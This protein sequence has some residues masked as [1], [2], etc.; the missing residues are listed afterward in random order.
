MKSEMR[1]VYLFVDDR[2]CISGNTIGVL[3]PHK[4]HEQVFVE[5]D[6]EYTN[7]F[8]TINKDD[9]KKLRVIDAKEIFTL[10]QHVSKKF[11]TYL[12]I[13]LVNEIE[14]QYD[15][16]VFYDTKDVACSFI[17]SFIEY[18]IRPSVYDN[19]ITFLQTMEQYYSKYWYSEKGVH[20]YNI[21]LIRYIKNIV[22]NMENINIFNCFDYG[23]QIS[24]RY[25]NIRSNTIQFN[26]KNTESI[27]YHLDEHMTGPAVI[28]NN[29]NETI[30]YKFVFN[31][32]VY[33]KDAI[34]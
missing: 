32:P 29:A 1:Q 5:T 23:I 15:D 7:L 24:V 27:L 18:R 6:D 2:R 30:V 12:I 4:I 19:L 25:A 13:I 11:S 10:F 31:L 21:R 20:K 34:Y 8:M 28:K 3:H 9:A 17:D 26:L 16:D 33:N 22:G 14:F